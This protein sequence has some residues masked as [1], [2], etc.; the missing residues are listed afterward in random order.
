MKNAGK[1]VKIENTPTSV[2]LNTCAGGP[3]YSSIYP[4]FMVFVIWTSWMWLDRI[5]MFLFGP[6]LSPIAVISAEPPHPWLWLLPTEAEEPKPGAQA[7]AL[8]V[9]E[10]F[11]SCWQSKLKCSYHESCVFHICIRVNNFYVYAFYP[12]PGHDVLLYGCLIDSDSG[13]R[14]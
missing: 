1:W 10:G 5:M 9:K 3:Q 8:Y 13:T 12:K 2:L 6:S 14:W 11:H 4:I 7:M